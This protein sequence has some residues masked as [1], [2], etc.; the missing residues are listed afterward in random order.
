VREPLSDRLQG[1][2]ALP[3]IGPLAA[4]PHQGGQVR[5]LGFGQLAQHFVGDRSHVLPPAGSGPSPPILLSSPQEMPDDPLAR[6]VVIGSKKWCHVLT[7]V[8]KCVML[9][10]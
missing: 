1:Q 2:R 6:S 9:M 8:Y 5:A 10:L 7:N 3:D 4:G